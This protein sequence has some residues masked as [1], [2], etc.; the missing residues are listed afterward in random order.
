[1]PLEQPQDPDLEGLELP[2]SNRAAA[3]AMGLK[4]AAAMIKNHLRGDLPDLPGGMFHQPFHHLPVQP[5]ASF[6]REALGKEELMPVRGLCSNKPTRVRIL[7][8]TLG[9]KLQGVG[10]CVKRP[11]QLVTLRTL[12]EDSSIINEHAS[13]SP[14]LWSLHVRLRNS[15]RGGPGIQLWV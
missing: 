3:P 1:M 10:V 2:A 14:A 8:N 6:R 12:P 7:N 11:F 15:L 4:G 9:F 13:L 5:P